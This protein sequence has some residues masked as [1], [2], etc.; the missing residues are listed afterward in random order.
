MAFDWF[1]RRAAS[2]AVVETGLGGRWDATNVCVPEVSV[3]TTV[4]RDHVEWLGRTLPDIAFEKAGIVRHRTPVVAGD[5]GAAARRVVEAAARRGRSSIWEMGRDLRWEED[6]RGR[7]SFHV[8][9]VSVRGVRLRA[10]GIFQRH[11]ALLACA[12]AWVVARDRD[13]TGRGFER[14]ARGALSDAVWPG[15]FTR[16][17]GRRNA[18]AWVDGAHNPSAARALA[19]E[20]ARLAGGG[21]ARRT[22]AIWS[23]LADK[24]IRGFVRTIAP[25]LDGVVAYPLGDE[26]G[27]ALP[28]LSAALA[29]AGVAGRKAETFP[30]AWETARRWAGRRGVTIVCGSL[31]VAADA[32]RFR[33]G[34]IP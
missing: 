22:V 25:V 6:G 20:L 5:L 29:G 15:R 3:I 27:A 7:L 9:G 26:R 31:M 24:D 10:P 34:S 8:P 1:R 19:A 33:V 12:A 14:A 16:L 18:G 2:L 30:E 13:C 23:M 28:A 4:A 11:N 21:K 32:Y 17:P